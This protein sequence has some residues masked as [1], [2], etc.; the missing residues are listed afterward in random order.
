MPLTSLEVKR[1][2]GRRQKR[3][4]E[5]LDA[6]AKVF[7]RRGYA[8]ASVQD[9]AD[10][11]GLLKGSLYHYTSS[12]E[13]LLYELLQGT[14]DELWAIMKESAAIAGVDALQ[15]LWF[16]VYR[17]VRYNINNL[18]RISIY[19]RDTVMLGEE[20]RQA[21][22][23]QRHEHE[24]FIADLI[25][26][27][28]GLDAEEAMI[29]AMNLFATIIWTHRWYR[30]GKYDHDKV[31]AL[32]ADYAVQGIAGRLD[33]DPRQKMLPIAKSSAN[34]DAADRGDD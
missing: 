23:A 9:I 14:H 17:Q 20:R 13:D 19:Y 34:G 2:T 30:D 16:Y 32:C 11:L 26:E 22:F 10:E 25:R 28:T 18:A 15:R 4:D 21:I 29:A 12:K 33:C 1:R 24:L 7:Y 6:A 5:V 8:A 31:P 27:A 3:R